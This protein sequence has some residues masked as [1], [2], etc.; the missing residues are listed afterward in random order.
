MEKLTSLLLEQPRAVVESG[1]V[2][3]CALMDLLSMA[4]DDRT[5]R[6]R[7]E[8]RYASQGDGSA[9]P[10]IAQHRHDH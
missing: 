8:V 9:L 5:C 10:R 4:L 7:S 6:F 3:P 2:I 1:V